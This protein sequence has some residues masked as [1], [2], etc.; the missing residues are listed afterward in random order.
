[1]L[2]STFM[3]VNA[4]M[5]LEVNTLRIDGYIPLVLKTIIAF[6]L[7]FQ[8][9]LLLFVLGWFGI[10]TSETLR[11]TRRWAIVI[12]FI[13]AM[14]LTP[15]DPMSQIIMAIPL[16]LMYEAAVWAV[17]LKERLSRRA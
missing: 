10:I 12:I 2:V 11:N 17:W 1:M 13:L 8:V 6:G 5:G 9:P 16:C 7:V 4:W 3:S 14:V 15:P